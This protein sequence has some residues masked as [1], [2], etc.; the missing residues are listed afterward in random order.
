M[1]PRTLTLTRQQYP[2]EDYYAQFVTK[3]TLHAIECAFGLERLCAAFAQ[4]HHLNS[5][6]LKQWDAVTMREVDSSGFIARLPFNRA[7]VMIAGDTITRSTLV[8][9][10]KCAARML[11]EQQ[12]SAPSVRAA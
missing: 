4:D 2:H 3:N 1:P 10:A 11:I 9:I 5:I 8:C 6:P 12:T 7:L